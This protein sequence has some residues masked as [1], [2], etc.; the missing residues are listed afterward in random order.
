MLEMQ[1]CKGGYPLKL[2]ED[3]VVAERLEIMRDRA[4]VS[5]P[6]RLLC[7][8][9]FELSSAACSSCRSLFQFRNHLH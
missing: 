4:K 8:L 3:M 9:E 6:R 5:S 1:Y 7:S 2:L